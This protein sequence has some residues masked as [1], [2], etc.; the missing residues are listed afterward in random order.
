MKEQKFVLKWI[1]QPGDA[2]AEDCF[3]LQANDI[4]LSKLEYLAIDFKLKDKEIVTFDGIVW[5]NDKLVNSGKFE[6][7]QGT[8]SHKVV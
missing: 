1:I 3:E 6:W 8:M 5:I 2:D 7:R 4:L